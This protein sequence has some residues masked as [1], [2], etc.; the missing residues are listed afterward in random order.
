MTPGVCSYDLNEAAV[1]TAGSTKTFEDNFATDLGLAFTG[2]VTS[3][4]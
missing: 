4:D 1:T 3:D 2:L